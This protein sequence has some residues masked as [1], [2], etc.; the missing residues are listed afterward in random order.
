MAVC[1]CQR[2]PAGFGRILIFFLSDFFGLSRAESGGTRLVRREKYSQRWEAQRSQ[3]S[4]ESLP[5]LQ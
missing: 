4:D 5:I 1:Q 3:A 2:L